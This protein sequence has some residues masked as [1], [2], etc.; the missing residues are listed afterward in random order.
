MKSS[1]ITALSLAS[2]SNAINLVKPRG[3]PQVLSYDLGRRTVPVEQLVKRDINLEVPL[4]NL[5]V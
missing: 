2:A 1:L 3:P 4:A 5:L